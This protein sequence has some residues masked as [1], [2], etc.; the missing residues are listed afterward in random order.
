M[1]RTAYNAYY[2]RRRVPRTEDGL[3]GLFMA[4]GKNI[5]IIGLG[6][7]GQVGRKLKTVAAPFAD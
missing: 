1:L 3:E 6:K 5:A 4:L 2:G 7:A